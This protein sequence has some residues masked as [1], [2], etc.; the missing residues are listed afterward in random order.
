MPCP[1]PEQVRDP[2]SPAVLHGQARGPPCP[3]PVYPSTVLS[4]PV[5]EQGQDQGG[6]GW[7]V[8]PGAHTPCTPL[9]PGG[10]CCS[11]TLPSASS[12]SAGT[13]PRGGHARRPSP[14]HP[15]CSTPLVEPACWSSLNSLIFRVVH[16]ITV[17]HQQ[18]GRCHYF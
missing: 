10:R 12:S 13:W 3:L 7:P 16:G 17:L 4:L 8:P 18:R 6:W 2:F 5:P 1:S 11:V 15:T 14:T 9:A